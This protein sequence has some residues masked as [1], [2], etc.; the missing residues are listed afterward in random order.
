MLHK[1]STPA[2]K[3]RAIEIALRYTVHDPTADR[4]SKD[5]GNIIVNS[6]ILET[7]GDKPW[8]DIVHHNDVLTQSGLLVN[9]T[10]QAIMREL[11]EANGYEFKQRR[12]NGKQTWCFAYVDNS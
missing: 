8:P 4:E 5:P 9:K 10:N 1:D 12:F 2:T 3:V 7:L 11:L 6:M